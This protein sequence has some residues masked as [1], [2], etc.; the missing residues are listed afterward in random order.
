MFYLQCYAIT[1]LACFGAD[2]PTIKHVCLLLPTMHA[3]FLWVALH[4]VAPRR[5]AQLPAN[6]SLFWESIRTVWLPL[7]CLM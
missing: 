3:E 6:V 5:H 7:L 1:N 4:S 2:V